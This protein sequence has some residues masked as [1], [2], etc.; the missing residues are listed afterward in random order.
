MRSFSPDTKT[1]MQRDFEKGGQNEL[2][3]LTG[4]ICALAAK[5]GT[6]TPLYDK[7]YSGLK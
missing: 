1:S 4:Y 2:D 5:L 3:A 7:A 6:K